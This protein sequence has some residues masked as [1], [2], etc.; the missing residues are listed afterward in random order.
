MRDRIEA[1]GGMLEIVSPADHGTQVR[2]TVPLRHGHPDDNGA[3]RTHPERVMAARRR[4]LEST[5]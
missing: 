5:A 1:A 4:P 3:R 2:G